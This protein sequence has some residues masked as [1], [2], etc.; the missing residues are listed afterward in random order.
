MIVLMKLSIITPLIYTKTFIT[1][2]C[3]SDKD[4]FSGCCGFNT[5]RCAGPIIAVQ[6]DGGCGFGDVS[7]NSIIARQ[8]GFLG[9][10]PD[11]NIKPKVKKVCECK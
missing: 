4:C 1:D 9:P 2:S 7:P 6:R 10:F 5:G 11:E 8:M 3:K